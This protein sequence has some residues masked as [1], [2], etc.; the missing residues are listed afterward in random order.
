VEKAIDPKQIKLIHVGI[1][2][3]GIDDG[4]YRHMLKARYGENSCKRLTYRQADDLLNYL[5]GLGFR[6]KGAH[7]SACRFI[8]APRERRERLPENVVLL[9]S[10]GR[11]RRYPGSARISNGR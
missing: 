6:I 1:S 4:A 7:K 2:R 8:C 11:S 10:Q 3:L 5:V 9:A